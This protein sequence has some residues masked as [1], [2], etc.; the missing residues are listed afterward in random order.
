MPLAVLMG[1]GVFSMNLMAASLSL[2]HDYQAGEVISADVLNENFERLR[3]SNADLPL[4][5]LQTLNAS[6]WQCVKYMDAAVH[7]ANSSVLSPTAYQPVGKDLLLYRTKDSVP[8]VLNIVQGLDTDTYSWTSTP[9]NAFTF[10]DDCTG[11]GALTGYGGDLVVSYTQCSDAA[12]KTSWLAVER[13][14]PSRIK[15]MPNGGQP[16]LL[17]DKS[18]QPPNA[19]TTLRASNLLGSVATNNVSI[20]LSWTDN[21]ADETGFRILRK[22]SLTEAYF[23]LD[24]VGVDK[25]NYT[26]ISINVTGH[27]WYRVEALN[28]A[29]VSTGSNAAKIT[30][31]N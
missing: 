6:D 16:V 18:N 25:V 12:P 2:P 11:S 21:S 14:S 13:K 17:C 8:V 28:G 23:L 15:I 22:N 9:V 24:S 10:D 1:M 29:L 5:E 26:D 31:I 27:Y 3:V 19:P 20:K 4:T 7:G 30:I